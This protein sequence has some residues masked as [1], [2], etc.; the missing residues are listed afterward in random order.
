MIQA[1]L[2]PTEH[3]PD[4]WEAVRPYINKVAALTYGRYEPDD[5]FDLVTNKGYLLWIAFDETQIR[6]V[7]V[8]FFMQYPR[9][10]YLYLLMCAGENGKEWKIPMLEL[11]Q[12]F[13]RDNNCDGMEATGRLGWAKIFHDQGYK[14]LWQVFELPVESFDG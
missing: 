14:P 9:T 6:G 5:V 12:R 2:V 13:A 11:L 8:T 1:S 3:V 4:I 10:K 7:V